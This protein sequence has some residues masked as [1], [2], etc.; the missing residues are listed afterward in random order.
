MTTEQPDI[1]GLLGAIAATAK[2]KAHRKR[3]RAIPPERLA[4]LLNAALTAENITFPTYSLLIAA[5]R[6]TR[7]RAGI[8]LARLGELVG[9]SYFATRQQVLRTP[10][11]VVR[12]G[13]GPGSNNPITVS[14]LPEAITKLSRITDRLAR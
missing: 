13:G 3:L 7:G 12:H 11:W 10:W 6:E 4:P 1:P 5:R 8:T 14:L 9:L 2:D